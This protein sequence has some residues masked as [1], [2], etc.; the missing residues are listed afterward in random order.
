MDN[1]IFKLYPFNLSLD[2]FQDE[3]KA[4]SLYVPGLDDALATL[5]DREQIAILSRYFKYET[6]DEVSQRLNV[7]RE[8]ARQIIDNAVNKL[9]NPEVRSLFEAAQMKELN[10]ALSEIELLNKTLKEKDSSFEAIDC[11]EEARKKKQRAIPL[12]QLGLTVRSFN[13]LKRSGISTAGQ[14]AD[15]K[16]EELRKIQNLGQRSVCD[17]I[18]KLGEVGLSLKG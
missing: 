5:S 12:E 2:I 17:I 10:F 3:K 8:G 16:V 9:R 14:I 15:L 13:C 18:Y 4:A 6:L 11:D 1:F 7:T